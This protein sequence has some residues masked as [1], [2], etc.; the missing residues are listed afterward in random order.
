MTIRRREF[1]ALAGATALSPALPRFSRAADNSGIYDLERFGNARILH[2]TDTHAQLLPVYFREPSVNLGIGA[3][4][5][6]PPHLVGRAFLARFGIKPDSADAYAFTFLDFEKSAAR[7]G[8]LG[9]FAHLKTLIDRLRSDAG[10]ENALL[11]DG[12]DLWQGTGLAN[13]MQGADMVE[14]ANLLGIEAMTGHWEFTYGEAALRANLDRFK[15]EFL[16]QNVFLTEEAAFN[17]AKAFDSASGRVFKPATIKKIGSYRVA[18]IGQAFPYVPIAHPRRFTPDWTFGIRDEELQKLVN[19]LRSNDKVDA[20]V[21]L[22]HNGMDVDLKLAGKVSGID[23]ILGGHTHDAVPQP[24]PVTNAGGTTLVT[25]AGS[26]GKFLGVLDLELTK[27]KVS[28][29]RYRL[30]PVFSELLK[31]DP[32]MAA[33]IEKMRSPHAATYAEKIITA[34]RLLYRRGNFGGTVDQLICD[35]LLS[36]FDAEIALSPGFRWGNSILPGQPVTMEDVLSETAVTYPETYLT[37]MTGGQIKD[38]LEDVCDN[39]FN[40]DP[41]HQ[42]GG[43]MVRVGGFTYTC[44]PAESVGRRISDVKLHNGRP[45]EAGKPYKVAGWA[46]VNEQQGKPVWEVFARHLGSG[47]MPEARGTG[48]TLKG[49]D[50][51]PGIAGQG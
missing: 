16:A 17:D 24:I 23:V 26:S 12:G 32:A 11:L 44:T 35:A 51:N 19:G 4:A 41:Y 30:L 31:P 25:N 40:A 37:S 13:T 46:S 10:P 22:S 38:I 21:L 50:D 20:V 18:V 48:V 5:G 45:M 3:M 6:K 8:K 39:L 36:E 49:I 33:L 43:D 27:G 14:A 34:D 29:V 42:Q 7:F 47:K 15:G 28:D 2:M 9:G 1:I